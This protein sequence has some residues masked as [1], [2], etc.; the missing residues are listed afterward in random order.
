MI[1]QLNPLYIKTRPTKMISRLISYALFEG[2]PLATKGRWINPLVFSLF[3]LEKNLPQLKRVEKPIFVVGMGR[4]GTTVLGVIL[5]MHRDAAF[6]NEPKALW[7]AVYSGE[8]VIGNYTQ[9]PARFRLHPKDATQEVCK[10]AQRIHGAYLTISA[11]NRVVCK[12]PELIFRIPFVLKIFPD[13]KFVFL[14]RNGWDT[15][16]SVAGWSERKGLKLNGETHDWWG[17]N[18]R[19]WKLMLSQLIASDK[20]FL[21]ILNEVSKLNNHNDMA[22]VEWIVSMREGLYQRER[23]YDCMYTLRYEDLMENPREILCDVSLFC[24]LAYDEKFISYAEKVLTPVAP[25]PSF[26]MHPAIYPLFNETMKSLGY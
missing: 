14:V 4:S 24:E 18:N 23:F 1:A 21:P 8:D 9:A 19:K 20:D 13:A 6:L 17:I 22:A 12:Y 11:A 3:M 2:R 10:A 26:E 5:S 25:H 16:H 7:N 15:C